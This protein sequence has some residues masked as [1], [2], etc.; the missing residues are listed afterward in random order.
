[1]IDKVHFGKRAGVFRKSLGI[2]Q[3]ELAEKLGVTPQAV[4]KW[5]VGSALP[6]VESLL[7]LS[8]LFGCTVNGLLEDADPMAE[9]NIGGEMRNGV[10]V[11][12]GEREI[13]EYDA[14]ARHLVREKIIPAS[15]EK[16]IQAPADHPFS[17]VG[18]RIAER[19]G[20][21]LEIGAGPGGGFT[22]F[23]LRAD[24]EARI[25]V[26][27][28]IPG[29]AA[30]W[31][32]HLDRALGSPNL[33][34]AACDFT[35]LP[36]PDGTFDTVSDCGGIVNTIGGERRT[37]LREA[38]RVLK[39][40]GALESFGIFVP[41]EDFAALPD[42]VRSA[43]ASHYPDAAGDLYAESLLAGFRRID[44]ELVRETCTDQDDSGFADACRALGVNLRRIACI[45]V[46]VKG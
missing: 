2:T 12:T 15:W 25:I 30:E 28:L 38:Y 24:E 21:I 18:R 10:R 29:V 41:A 40:G 31:K 13:A 14:F 4:S 22:P 27:D 45:R 23:V 3:T 36:F 33:W 32:R 44:T 16:A 34:Y 9:M 5:E 19:G 43:L 37:A 11:F 20:L 8:H 39:P 7:A 6:D 17:A 35:A 42:E 1:M 26:S 46:C